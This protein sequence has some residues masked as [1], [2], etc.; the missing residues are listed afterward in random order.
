MF[1]LP[2]DNGPL[3]Y[4]PDVTILAPRGQKRRPKAVKGGRK[5][6]STECASAQVAST[7]RPSTNVASTIVASSSMA[8]TKMASTGKSG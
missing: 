7:N 1:L 8:S 2:G 3:V 6:A 5:V 4:N